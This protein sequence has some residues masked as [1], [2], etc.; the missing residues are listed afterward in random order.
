ML[1][2]IKQGLK[3]TGVFIVPVFC[4]VSFLWITTCLWSE[5]GCPAQQ[6]AAP[7]SELRFCCQWEYPSPCWETDRNA[8]QHSVCIQ[9]ISLQCSMNN[10]GVKTSAVY[11]EH[12]IHNFTLKKQRN[13]KIN[14]KQ[15]K[16]M[17]VWS[18]QR[19]SSITLDRVIEYWNSY[20]T[21]AQRLL[22]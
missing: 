22:S 7:E 20:Y 13:K 14:N 16:C 12:W 15:K 21:V 4:V 18:L 10:C 2:K 11:A 6:D 5:K 17:T 1:D 9:S 19:F 8:T 3:L